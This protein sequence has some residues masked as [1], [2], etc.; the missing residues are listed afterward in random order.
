MEKSSA[1]NCIVAIGEGEGRK[2]HPVH[3]YP[4]VN[5]DNF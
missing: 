3:A 4:H 5:V 2:L 1:A